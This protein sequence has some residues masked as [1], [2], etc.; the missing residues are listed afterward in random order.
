MD[1][2]DNIQS[3]SASLQNTKNLSSLFLLIMLQK[4]FRFPVYEVVHSCYIVVAL[5]LR[6]CGYRSHLEQALAV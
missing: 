4:G 1:A 6:M 5:A 3:A 2:A